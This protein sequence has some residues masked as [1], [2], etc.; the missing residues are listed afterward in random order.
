MSAD[1]KC[2][3]DVDEVHE[4]SVSC[5]KCKATL[6]SSSCDYDTAQQAVLDAATQ[7]GWGV[8]V[9]DGPYGEW[10]LCADCLAMPNAEGH[11]QGKPDPTKDV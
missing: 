8:G 2:Y 1:L 11:V 6:E 7:A 4:A 3:I 10:S 5:A 9:Y